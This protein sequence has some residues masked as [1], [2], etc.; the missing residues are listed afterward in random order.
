MLAYNVRLT[1]G[2][3]CLKMHQG[4]AI[5]GGFTHMRIFLRLLI[6][7]CGSISTHASSL[8]RPDDRLLNALCQI[9]SNGGKYVSGDGGLSLGHFQ[10]QR[11]AWT[12]VVAWRKKRNLPTHDYRS[13]V[14]DPRISRIY[15]ADYLTIL[16]A[17]LKSEYR[18]E[19]TPGEL[20]AAYNMGLSNFR[21]CNY[22]MAN[23][24]PVTR[25]KCRE[26]TVLVVAAATAQP[27]ISGL[28][29]SAH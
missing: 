25:G 2:H 9:E 16:Q 27:V 20:Y 17:R 14:F 26:I 6:C 1:N 12:D 11:A 19:A 3:N 24:N 29:S 21:K 23:V 5:Y 4:K 7:L 10:I 28:S 13:N 18:R 22:D 8:W 15:A